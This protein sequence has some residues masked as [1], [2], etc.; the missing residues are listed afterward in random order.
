MSISDPD[1]AVAKVRQIAF[2]GVMM[3]VLV[4][5]AW[6]Q[7]PQFDPYTMSFF[8]KNYV[9]PTPEMPRD[10]RIFGGVMIGIA[11]L[12]GCAT[13]Q[14]IRKKVHDLRGTVLLTLMGIEIA[15]FGGA[16]FVAADAAQ[17]RIEQELSP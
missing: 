8:S 1:N 9:T 15:A 5:L 7:A 13:V 3:P 11:A 12:L 6:W 4:A 14:G 2:V 16:F 17:V 10:L